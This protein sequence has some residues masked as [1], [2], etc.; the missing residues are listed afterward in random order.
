VQHPSLQE[1]YGMQPGFFFQ[2]DLTLESIERSSVCVPSQSYLRCIDHEP[3]TGQVLSWIDE[4]Y[5]EM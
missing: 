1:C 4:R 2:D 5:V 3:I